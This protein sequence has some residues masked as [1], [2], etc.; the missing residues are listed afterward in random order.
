MATRQNFTPAQRQSAFLQNA[1]WLRDHKVSGV[2]MALS[3]EHLRQAGRVYYCENCLFCH[4]S[5]E[6]F[7]IDHL[8]PDKLFRDWARHGESRLP[9]NM[10]VLCKSRQRGDLGCNQSKSSRTLVPR[11]RGLAYTIPSMDM[12]CCPVRER[13]FDWV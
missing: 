7:D 12:N 11:H 8:V 2:D 3:F 1:T 9:T 10:I 6:Y 13:P 4:T 5:Q